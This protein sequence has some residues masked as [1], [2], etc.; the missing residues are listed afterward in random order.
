[1]K[2]EKSILA[3][4]VS[5]SGDPVSYV[6]IDSCVESSYFDLVENPWE[7]AD[8][9]S[10]T[11]KQKWDAISKVIEEH[12]FDSSDS[13]DFIT[14]N[15]TIEITDPYNDDETLKEMKIRAALSK[16]SDSE[17]KVLGITNLFTYIKTKYHNS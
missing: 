17:I 11:E 7:A 2:T 14:I 4:R 3:I 16:L 10:F 1:M 5:L 9:S 12:I 6:G 15:T 13:A 8:F